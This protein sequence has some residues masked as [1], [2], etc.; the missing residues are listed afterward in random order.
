MP[1]VGDSTRE[2]SREGE[3]Q[4]R[5]EEV[6]GGRQQDSEGRALLLLS[7][8][9]RSIVP[10]PRGVHGGAR[11][12]RGQPDSPWPAAVTPRHNHRHRSVCSAPK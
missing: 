9:F 6:Q 3:V 12:E 10:R 2:E 8:K 5:I 4:R 1:E 7:L 11:S